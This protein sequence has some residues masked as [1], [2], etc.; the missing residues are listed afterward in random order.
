[1]K[2]V[3]TTQQGKMWAGH[4]CI[5]SNALIFTN[6]SQISAKAT[7]QGKTAMTEIV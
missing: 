6:M 2:K 1:M 4:T 5:Y 3:G 7:S